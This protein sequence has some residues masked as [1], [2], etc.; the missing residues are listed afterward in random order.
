MDV[1]I[2]QG[3]IDT[4]YQHGEKEST[5]SEPNTLVYRARPYLSQCRKLGEEQRNL[6]A[7]RETG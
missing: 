3:S 6:P 1:V 5:S 7:L 4:Q 2:I